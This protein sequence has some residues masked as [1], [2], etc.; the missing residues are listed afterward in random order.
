MIGE[1]KCPVCNSKHTQ[2][3]FSLTSGKAGSLFIPDKPELSFRISREIE[4]LWKSN[5]CEFHKC[6]NC[7]FGFAWPFIAGN[8]KI[9][10]A[11]YYKDFSFLAD[12]WEYDRAI[13]IIRDLDLS[14]D[15]TLLELG[16]GNGSFLDKVSTIINDKSQIYSTEYSSAGVEEIQ[17]KGF[18]C[19]NKSISE[20]QKENLPEFDIICMFQV[21]EHMDDLE[22]VFNT[23]GKLGKQASHLIIAVPN[24]TLRSFY[25]KMGVHLDVPPIHVGRFTPETFH[26]IG[27][28]HGWNIVE[29]C[30]E[31]QKYVFK[32]KKFVFDRYARHQF[33]KRTER[34]KSKLLKYFFRYTI[35]ILLSICF[36]PVLI[37]LILAGN[38]TSL[39]VHFKHQHEAK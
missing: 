18:K 21:L 33:A 37:Y 39:F 23:L 2:K 24:G 9:Y 14:T 6:T 36:L 29:T 12:K 17:R 20:L 35:V 32:V 15:S 28:K 27:R 5:H 16:A 19:Y 30:I 25:D 4:A 13:E 11:L 10:S 3:V 8:E 31:P 7:M 26:F 38:G 1:I 22:L 34:S